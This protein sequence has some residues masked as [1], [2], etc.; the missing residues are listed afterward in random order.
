M[1]AR[2]NTEVSQT[3]LVGDMYGYP[4]LIW[5]NAKVISNILSMTRVEKY[6]PIPYR[7]QL[8]SIKRG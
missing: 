6:F 1:N 3:N 2:G 8:S 7:K 4:E 5:Y